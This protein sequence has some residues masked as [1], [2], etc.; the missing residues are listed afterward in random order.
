MKSFSEPSTTFMRLIM[1]L[2]LLI[3]Y[4][5]SVWANDGNA[6]KK[7]TG[8]DTMAKKQFYQV[9][10]LGTRPGWP[11]NMTP[12]EEKIM[13]D[14]FNY[15]KDLTAKKKVILAGP[16]TDPVFGLIIL[17]VDSRG[18]ADAI[19]EKEPSVIGGVHTYEMQPMHVSLLVDHVSSSRYAADPS[20]KILRKEVVVSASRKEVWDTWT[21]TEGVNTFFSGNANVKLAMGGPFEIYFLMDAP[22]GQRGSED[23]QI[24]GWLPEEMLT[25]EWNAPPNFGELRYIKTRIVLQFEDAPDGKTKVT[26]TQL[27]W[28][29]GEKWDELYAYFDRA[30]SYVLANLKKRFDE[31]PLDL[32]D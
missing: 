22:A 32:S 25:F 29:K 13:S 20:D 4:M 27:G 31:G 11:E 1:P 21:T 8:G 23:C 18:E 17:Q 19:M 2:L 3:L 16:C 9:R 7:S 6:S 28:G 24:L 30:W 26:L 5:A 12:E 14:H 15:L 10:L